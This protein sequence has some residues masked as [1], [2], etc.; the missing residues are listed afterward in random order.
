MGRN[1]RHFIIRRFNNGDEYAINAMFNEVFN[2]NRDISHWYWKYR[3]NPCGSHFISLALDKNGT[4]AAHYG[5]YPLKLHNYPPGANPS[6]T[7]IFHLGDKMTRK[8]FRAM[9]FG[10]SSL[11]ARTFMHF[12]ETFARDIPFGYGFGTHHSL[13][14]GLLFLGYAEI[15]NITYR[16]VSPQKLNIRK[17]SRLR[18]LFSDV[19]INEVDEMDYSWTDFFYR[20]APYYGCLI[21]RDEAY[22]NWRYLKRPDRKYLIVSARNRSGLAGWTVFY[23]EANKV[24]WGDAMFMQTD[25]DYLNS[26]FSYVQRHP[27]MEG[28]DFIECWFSERPHWWDAGLKKIG[29][30]AEAEPNDLRL[31][32]P[33]FNDLRAPEILKSNFY[34]TMGDSD[35]F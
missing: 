34:Y 30:M 6:E 31:T 21:K 5:G 1:N 33:V 23:R 10:A 26:I 18:K 35:L 15:E 4:L 7:T 27:I 14:F 29:F 3:D 20:A 17:T 28:A 11:L 12:K 24:V 13:R 32:G 19:K 2:Q 9:G 22:L 25:T 16:R 8:Q